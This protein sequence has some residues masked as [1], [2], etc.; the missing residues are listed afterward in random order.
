MIGVDAIDTCD[1]YIGNM[2]MTKICNVNEAFQILRTEYCIKSI[3]VAMT[4]VLHTI[5][6]CSHCKV[7]FKLIVCIIP[8]SVIRKKTNASSIGPCVHTTVPLNYSYFSTLEQGW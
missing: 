4:S 7:R 8:R 5:Y 2:H 3:N 1:P 6:I